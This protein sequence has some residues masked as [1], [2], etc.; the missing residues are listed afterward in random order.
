MEQRHAGLFWGKEAYRN[1]PEGPY[2]E[3]EGDTYRKKRVMDIMEF[4][5]TMIISVGRQLIKTYQQSNLGR[6]RRKGRVKTVHLNLRTMVVLLALAHLSSTLPAAEAGS[7]TARAKALWKAGQKQIEEGLILDAARTFRQMEG[8]CGN[9]DLCRATALFYLGRCSLEQ[10]DFPV[11]RD[12]VER[13]ERIY[14]K[15]NKPQEIATIRYTKGRIASSQG[16]C[17]EALAYYR[18]SESFFMRHSRKAELFN[19]LCNM[20]IVHA[21]L[22]NYNEAFDALDRAE[23]CVASRGESTIRGDL[24]DTR[25]RVHLQRQEYKDAERCFKDASRSYSQLGDKYKTCFV[26]NHLGKL[27]EATSAYQKASS[28][29]EKALQLALDNANPREEAV[30]LNNLGEIHYKLG[31][32]TKAADYFTKANSIAKRLGLKWL[33]ATTTGNIGAASLGRA[34]Y[35]QAEEHFRQSLQIATDTG[36]AETMGLALHNMANL[37]KFRGAF[38]ESLR[39]SGQAIDVARRIGNRRLESTALVRRGNLYEYFGVFNKAIRD[40]DKA[41]NIQ[42]EIGDRFF[43]SVTLADIAGILARRGEIPESRS[44]FVR[45]LDISREIGAPT[46]ELLCK[47]ALTF[48]EGQAYAA[49]RDSSEQ[50]SNLSNQPLMKPIPRDF[51]RKVEVKNAGRT[52]KVLVHQPSLKA[53]RQAELMEAKKYIDEAEKELGADAFADML[54]LEYVKGKWLLPRRPER[55]VAHFSRLGNQSRE[56]G[57]RRFGFLANVGLGLSFEALNKLDDAEQAFQEAIDF[58]EEIRKTLDPRMK[59]SFLHGEEILGVKHILPYEGLARVLLKRGDRTKSLE[60]SELAKARAFADH[61]RFCVGKTHFGISRELVKGLE[62]VETRIAANE[63][64]I[65]ACRE[66]GTAMMCGISELESEKKR[67]NRHFANVKGNLAARCP[68]FYEMRFPRPLVLNKSAVGEKE[69]IIEY[70]VTDSGLLIYAVKGKELK[71]VRFKEVT[72]H[73]LRST[74]QRFL[75]PLRNWSDSTASQRGKTHDRETSKWLFD[76]LLADV[77][78]KAQTACPIIIIPDDCLGSLPFEMLVVN[79]PGKEWKSERGDNSQHKEP[80]YFGDLFPVSYYHSVTAL[81]L[82]RNLS[83]SRQPGGRILVVAD[84]VF[85]ASDERVSRVAQRKRKRILKE[86]MPTLMA[87]QREAGLKWERLPLTSRLADTARLLYGK[88]AEVYEGFRAR[89]DMIFHDS[90]E[91]YAAVI[92]AT[93]GYYGTDLPGIQEP[94]LALTMVDLPKGEDGYLRMTEVMNLHLNAD[95]VAL[96]A[97]QTALGERLA[98][99]GVLNL[100]R[101]FQYAGAKSVLMSVWSVAEDSSVKLVESFLR[102][103]KAGKQKSEALQL[104]RRDIRKDGYEHPFYWAAFVLA[105]EVE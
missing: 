55:A 25:G 105:G 5:R 103:L 40:Y 35:V 60:V 52:N 68:L 26:L 18:Q 63:K 27:F 13:A 28:S 29:Y 97:C 22:G 9:N 56:R 92:M 66:K 36:S 54:L 99:E 8:A 94:M 10:S 37:A 46:T 80:V 57:N 4:L 51:S 87:L 47:L 65:Q 50:A 83:K 79:D 70:L 24:S 7:D 101:A 19:V 69:L 44:D 53:G 1:Q 17:R 6:V 71:A 98:G 41:L 48:I 78:P 43:T 59:R 30:A 33:V 104:A 34:E 3:R 16:N 45:A 82:A 31:S 88:R 2:R 42:T 91:Q 21:E 77:L 62:N 75:E 90:L 93:H 96:T 73:Q 76:L 85:D 67:L 23:Q 102:H 58:A 84:P 81:T 100:G 15:L 39:Y 49:G 20:A 38:N 14:S 61:L 32:Y 64:A 86:A 12:L 11:A 72:R 89:K 95:I 74:V